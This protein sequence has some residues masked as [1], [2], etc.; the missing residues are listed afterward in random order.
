[1]PSSRGT[2]DA[3][4]PRLSTARSPTK[5]QT[6]EAITKSAFE[7]AFLDF[8]DAHALPRPKTNHPLGPYE[9]DALWPNERVI[10]ELDGYAIHTTRQAFEED[11]ERDR[12]LQANGYRVLRITWRQLTTTPDALAAKLRSHLTAGPRPR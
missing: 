4:G 7:Q 9:P 10:V 11:R 8:L 5:R 3:K 12:D 2:R 6:G 1:M